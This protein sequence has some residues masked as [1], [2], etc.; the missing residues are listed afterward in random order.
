MQQSSQQSIKDLYQYA[1]TDQ[2]FDLSVISFIK[3]Y[4]VKYLRQ[5]DPKYI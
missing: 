1:Q 3:E 5:S 4:I 2:L